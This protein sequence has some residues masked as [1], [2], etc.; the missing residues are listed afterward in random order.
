MDWIHQWVGLRSILADCI[1]SNFPN[2]FVDWVELG[3]A[4]FNF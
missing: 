2:F 3:Q 1:G 4:M